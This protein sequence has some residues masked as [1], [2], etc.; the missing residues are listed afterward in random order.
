MDKPSLKPFRNRFET[1]SG[2]GSGSCKESPPSVLLDPSTATKDVGLERARAIPV[3]AET[4]NR[5]LRAYLAA[6]ER[7][8]ELFGR[9]QARA[10]RADCDSSHRIANDLADDPIAKRADFERWLRAADDGTAPS[11][12]VVGGINWTDAW[13]R[14]ADAAKRAATM[15][16]E[17]RPYDRATDPLL[18]L[19]LREVWTDLTGETLSGS[20]ARCPSPEH[21]DEW[22]SCAVRARLF[23]CNG[24]PASGSIIDLGALLYGIEPR[25]RG[26]FEIR[27]RLLAA[28]AFEEAA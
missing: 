6:D 19:D 2:S 25:G 11:S 24:C 1:H 12:T 28:L 3:S 23:F 17:R 7:T 22:P 18:D 9:E 10:I 13:Q 21:E 14:R 8:R 4:G 26:F 15:P 5:R 16:G 20:L 27:R